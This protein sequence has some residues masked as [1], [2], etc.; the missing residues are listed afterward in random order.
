MF[1]NRI[2]FIFFSFVFF[3]NNFILC[4]LEELSVG[5]ENAKKGIKDLLKGEYD[6][7]GLANIYCNLANK[8]ADYQKEAKKK[9]D[10]Q[11]L[12]KLLSEKDYT[13]EAILKYYDEAIKLDDGIRSYGKRA[14]FWITRDE[15]EKA[16]LDYSNQMAVNKKFWDSMQS[17][18]R[19]YFNLKKYKEAKADFLLLSKSGDDTFETEAKKFLKDIDRK[20]NDLHQ[21]IKNVIDPLLEKKLTSRKIEKK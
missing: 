13:D 16:I 12:E 2:C 20:E 6:R 4:S 1:N 11:E 15:E 17:R 7:D 5:I 3:L 18:A 14:Y 21:E 9:Y 19:L 8:I 10:S